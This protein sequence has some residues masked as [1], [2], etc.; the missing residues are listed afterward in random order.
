MIKVSHVTKFFD[1]YKV[2]DEISLN[3]KKGSI[4]GLIGPNGAGKTT[5]IN[6]ING[7]LKPVSG[8]IF[9]GGEKVW[10]NERIKRKIL[11]FSFHMTEI[12]IK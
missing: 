6:H 3:V 1:D 11:N 5:I 2:L 4:Y 9:V 10:E 12:S 8:D 7:V